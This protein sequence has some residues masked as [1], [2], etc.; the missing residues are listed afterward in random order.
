MGKGGSQE[1]PFFIVL[2]AS[3]HVREAY[4]GNDVGVRIVARLEASPSEARRV[5]NWR[6]G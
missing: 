3:D 5:D 6:K 1:P 2:S 4:R